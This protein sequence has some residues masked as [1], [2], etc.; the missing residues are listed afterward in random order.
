MPQQAVSGTGNAGPDLLK[1]PHGT[2]ER[3]NSSLAVRGLGSGCVVSGRAELAEALCRKRPW[4]GSGQIA[5]R[6]I[7]V[8]LQRV[9]ASKG[10]WDAC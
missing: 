5:A 3:D 8:G 9:S 2:A 7:I 1:D 4:T 10:L 6:V